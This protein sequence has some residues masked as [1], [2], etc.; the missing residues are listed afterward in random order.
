MNF[1]EIAPNTALMLHI[2]KE[3]KQLNLKIHLERH[4]DETTAVIRLDYEGGQILNFTGVTI[5]LEFGLEQAAPFLWK[6]VRV[7]YHRGIYVLKVFSTDG[8]KT[9][10]RDSFRVSIGVNARTNNENLSSVMVKDISHSGFALTSRKKEQLL[11]IGETIVA[12]FD[13]L[14]FHIRLEGTLVR[15]EERD[16]IYIYGFKST[17]FCPILPQYIAFKQRPM[18]GRNMRR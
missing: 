13:D 6:N 10:R 11:D 1:I 12:T 7:L 14:H 2:Y 15:V 16:G 5:D 3:S 18:T 17:V 9:N 4:L 8:I